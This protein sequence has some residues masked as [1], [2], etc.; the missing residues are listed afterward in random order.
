M[1]SQRS[2][3]TFKYNRSLG[4]HGWLRLTPAYSVKLVG[5]IIDDLSDAGNILD[6]FSGTATTGVAA[7]E[8]G[9][10]S[11]LFDINPFLVWF[12]N[13]KLSNLSEDDTTVLRDTLRKI[14][15]YTTD[16]Q[17]ESLWLPPLKNIERWWSKNTLTIL[18]QLRAS[19]VKIIG[20][21][22]NAGSLSLLWIAFARVAIE[23]SAAAFNHV[24]VSFHDNTVSHSKQEILLA[25]ESYAEAFIASAITPLTGEGVVLLHDSSSPFHEELQFDAIITSPPYPNRMSYI[26]ELRPYMFWLG[27]LGEAREAGE[28]DWQA[29]GGTWGIATSRLTTWLPAHGCAMHSLD[30]VVEKIKRTGEKNSELLSLYVKKYFYDVDKHIRLI[31][32]VLK[33][34]A[35]VHY[36]IGNS[37]FYGVHVATPDLYEESFL[38]HGFK[39]VSSR[40]IRKRN[41]KKELFEYCTSA[42]YGRTKREY[43]QTAPDNSRNHPDKPQYEQL[44]LLEPAAKYRKR[45]SQVDTLDVL[46]QPAGQSSTNSSS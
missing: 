44:R 20:E 42:T 7:A 2:D 17:D 8:R 4:R 31:Q 25:F 37:T 6:P 30:A 1:I 5:K 32:S 41:S 46:L 23:H 3:Y 18:A 11:T 29:I 40:I 45:N 19:L 36:V 28:L 43:H 33:P 34:G 10:R 24:S 27:F 26:R 13:T 16:S 39:N 21:P 12:G 38:A 15:L 22:K 14:V 9:H 35:E